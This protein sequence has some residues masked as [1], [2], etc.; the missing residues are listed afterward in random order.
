VLT[1]AKHAG[2]AQEFVDLVLS[3]DGAEV[4][5]DAGFQKP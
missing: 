1:H 2:Q 4:L 3:S 5:R